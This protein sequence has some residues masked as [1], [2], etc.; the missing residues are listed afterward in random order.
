MKV[1]D[2]K[3]KKARRLLARIFGQSRTNYILA[4]NLLAMS[5]P[6]AFGFRV[7]DFFRP[8][9]FG[10][11][12]LLP[13]LAFCQFTLVPAASIPDRPEKLSFPPLN[14]EP[15]APEKFRVPLRAGPIAYVV[16]DRELPLVNIVV[17]VRTGK[18]LEPA[19]KEGL[20]DL[21]G[22]LLARGG[23]KSK[24]ADELEERLA[25]LAANLNSGVG[26][27]QGSVSL[28]LLS[29]DIEEGLGILREVLSTPRFQDD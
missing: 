19:G 24:T 11:R 1:R 15:P 28:N 12:T 4:S 23:I 26:D 7:S 13:F 18:Y 9:D 16:P 14:Y 6:P 20:A 2:S 29:K 10:L 5:R 21:T 8:S 27:T 3:L 17:Y 25:F 22:Y